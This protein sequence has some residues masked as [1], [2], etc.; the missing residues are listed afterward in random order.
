MRQRATNTG[1]KPRLAAG[2]KPG[3]PVATG[4]GPLQKNTMSGKPK[5]GGRI[6]PKPPK[7]PGK[8]PQLPNVPSK[9]TTNTIRATGGNSKYAKINRLSGQTRAI[10]GSRALAPAARGVSAAMRG[11]AGKAGAVGVGANLFA[12]G[13]SGSVVDQAVKKLPG[14]KANPKTDLGKRAGDAIGR[15]AAQAAAA[16][17]KQLKKAKMGY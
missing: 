6:P 11:V 7:G 16:L 2:V 1:A 15:T 12:Q 9:G 3:T 4:K 14:I 5:S 13:K 8:G 10:T 17:K